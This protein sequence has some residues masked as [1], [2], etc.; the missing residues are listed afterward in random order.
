MKLT[1][2]LTILIDRKG[3]D[4]TKAFA[5]D[6]KIPY[7]TIDGLYKKGYSNMK[8]FTLKALCDYFNVTLDSMAYDDREIEYRMGH[9]GLSTADHNILALYHNADEE[10]RKFVY[11]SLEDH[12]KRKEEQRK[13]N[14][15]EKESSLRA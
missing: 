13:E 7:T 6:S 9:K 11:N 14:L 8:I 12:C 4:S 2:K 1:D 15:R 10:V 3:F 5:E